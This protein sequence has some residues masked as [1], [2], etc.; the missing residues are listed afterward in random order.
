MIKTSRSSII[1]FLVRINI[2]SI[3]FNFKIFPF[4]IAMKLP[5]LISKRTYIS[6]LKRGRIILDCEISPGIIQIGYGKLAVFDYKRSRSVIEV[7]GKLIV[8]GNVRIGFGSKIIVG[9]NGILELGDNFMINAESTIIALKKITIK[10]DVLLAWDILIMDDDLHAIID[11]DT[12]L[13]VNK[14]REI[15]ICEHVWIGARVLILKGSTI[16]AHS[17]VAANSVVTGT[18]NQPYTVLGGG[19]VKILRKNS[20]WRM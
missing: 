5:L 13:Q 17:V 15:I 19:P 16:P 8:K 9:D 4:K 14:S 6:K 3:Y 7:T 18:H 20:T 1:K 12:M 2:R 11:K 10:N